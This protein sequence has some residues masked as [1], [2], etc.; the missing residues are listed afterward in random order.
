MRETDFVAMPRA[1]LTKEMARPLLGAAGTDTVFYSA[2]LMQWPDGIFSP[3]SALGGGF[4]TLLNQLNAA[5]ASHGVSTDDLPIAFDEEIET[6]ANWPAEAHF[7]TM[8]A[9]LRVRD[10]DRARKIVEALTSIPIEGTEWTRD[11][12]NGATVFTVQP[13]GSQLPLVPTISLSEKAIYLGT[14]SVAVEN[15]RTRLA[16]PARD[17]ENSARFRDAVALVPKPDC[18]FDYVDTQQAWERLDAALRPFLAM[19]ATLYP[20]LG[21]G[22]DLRKVPPSEVVTKHLSPIVMSQRYEKEGYVTDSAGP[23]TFRAATLG[24]GVAIGGSLVHLRQGL[25]DGGNPPSA[26]MTPPISATASPFPTSSAT[27]PTP[28]ATPTPVSGSP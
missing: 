25:K 20:A 5:F 28:T 22:V 17:L 19:S 2:S 10:S 3:A 4:S 24:L 27:T 7:P 14:E 1:G 11:E 21:N 9:S 13:F 15:L 18:A 12:Q 26:T 23:V 16:K 8:V 6:M